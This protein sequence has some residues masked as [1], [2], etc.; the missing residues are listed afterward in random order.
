M[1]YLKCKGGGYVS[2]RHLVSWFDLWWWNADA[3]VGMHPRKLSATTLC[4]GLF[5]FFLLNSL[6]YFIALSSYLINTDSNH[7][8]SDG[9]CA[10]DRS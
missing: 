9:R 5:S 10:R 4:A 1:V 2:S 3:V 8:N 7:Y 6:Q